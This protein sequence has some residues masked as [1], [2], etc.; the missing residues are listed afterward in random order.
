[1]NICVI[2]GS[3]KGKQSITL[4]HIHYGSKKNP[5]AD[6]DIIDVAGRIVKIEKDEDRFEAIV[7]KMAAADAVIWSF[8]V[9]YA[10]VPSQLKRFVE[11]LYERCAP[12]LFRD[13][14]TTSFTTSINFFDH[15]AHNYMQGV[16]EELGFQYIKGY[17]AHM[18]DFFREKQREAMNRFFAWF[19]GMVEQKV[20]VEK[21]YAVRRP[22]AVIYRPEPVAD[23]EIGSRQRVLL[24]TDGTEEDGNLNRMVAVFRKTSSMAVEEINLHDI[25]MKNG[26]TGCCNCG[27]DNTCRQK[28]GFQ[29]FFSD[30]F[31][32]ADIIIIAGTIRDHYLSAL[33]K[34]FFDRSFFNGHAPVLMGKRLG[35]I[36]SGPLRRI[37]N[38]R[39]LLE[40]YGE[41][42]HMK[43]TGIVT[44][45][46][47]ASGEITG[48]IRAFAKELE[49]VNENNMA[50]GA[51]FYRV[52]GSKIFRDFIYNTRAVFSAD[53]SFYKKHGFYKDF[54]QRQIKKRLLN[55]SFS[56]FLCIPP[57]RKRIHKDF[58]P[59]MVAPYKKVLRRLS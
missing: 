22:K 59:G 10:L 20:A 25:P 18:D 4:Q 53:H 49:L 24:L 43:T 33:W 37:Q 52:G 48:H 45:E 46:H 38:L 51:R 31:K 54:P 39:E 30:R 36:I 8:P 7:N 57:L 58:I 6:F 12:G 23:R 29:E 21:K 55:I 11:L 15:T 56:F 2:N 40:A 27:Y 9:Y 34:R 41:I 50:F 44:D 1:M 13:T 17:S 16:C 35:F 5:E 42:W 47:A 3:P 19:V 26:C 28:D 14:Y 32:G